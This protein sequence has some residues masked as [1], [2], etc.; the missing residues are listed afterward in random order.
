MTAEALRELRDLAAALAIP[1]PYSVTPA[2]FRVA[3][4]SVRCPECK[5]IPSSHGCDR[6]SLEVADQDVRICRQCGC[7]VARKIGRCC[8]CGEWL[9]GTE[10]CAT[11]VAYMGR[12]WD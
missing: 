12:V 5:G 8:K 1:A 4:S 7:H 9:S 6:C 3:T 11:H 2:L 10:R